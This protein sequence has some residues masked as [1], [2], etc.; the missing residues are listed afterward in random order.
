MS[1]TPPRVRRYRIKPGES[2]VAPAPTR[3]ANERRAVVET[4]S[5]PQPP[6]KVTPIDA[7]RSVAIARIAAEGLSAPSLRRARQL[8]RL[9]GLPFVNDHD[10]VRAL[11]AAGLVYPPDAGGPPSAAARKDVSPLPF[12]PRPGEDGLPDMRPKSPGPPPAPRPAT[13]QEIEDDLAQFRAI[14]KEVS[15]RRGKSRLRFFQRMLA[16]IVAPTAIAGL[17]FSIVATPIYSA[18][19]EFTVKS[20][21]D[22]QS[23][24]LA[25]GLPGMAAGGSAGDNIM[26]QDYLGSRSAFHAI[27]KTV[28]FREFFRGPGIDP[29]TRIPASADEEAI[30]ARYQDNVSIAFTPT[31]GVIRMNVKTPFPGA[32]KEISDALIALAK[33]HVDDLTKPIR[34][35]EVTYAREAVDAE[36]ARLSKAQV[37]LLT[38]QGRHDTLSPDFEAKVI[39]QQIA[40]LMS[41]LVDEKVSL[42]MIEANARPNRTQ[43]DISKRKIAAIQAEID[44]IRGR[45]VSTSDGQGSL[46]KASSDIEA[47]KSEVKTHQQILA[48]LTD[49]LIQARQQA[50]SKAR[51]VA[52]A[53]SPM[54][55]TA[56][57][58]P[59][60]LRDT[61][62]A[63]VV[64]LLSYLFLS[65]TVSLLREEIQR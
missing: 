45:M 13:P 6:E 65:L 12:A 36:A 42:S 16:F 3:L 49:Q 59:R 58:Y 29:L 32:S 62:I 24:P 60:P 48:K 57:E 26:L 22:L 11:R 34:D 20:A 9:K 15:G 39:E 35:A 41:R 56:A 2:L 14:Q 7:E 54:R 43:M 19:S 23:S 64:I 25:Q 21:S 31:E 44:K 10:A 63:F 5:A 4:Q 33:Q 55:P 1:P 18:H 51:F 50:A 30:Y 28:G 61:A 52:V 40:P 17:W 38:A 46:A 47:A 53:V 8:A 37:A 27:E